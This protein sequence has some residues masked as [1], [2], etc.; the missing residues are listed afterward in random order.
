MS[1]T[2]FLIKINTILKIKS[3]QGWNFFLTMSSVF[4]PQ[5]VTSNMTLCF[6]LVFSTV[7]V[8]YIV[9]TVLNI[10]LFFCF[11]SFKCNIFIQLDKISQVL[12]YNLH[13]S[14]EVTD[15]GQLTL[16]QSLTVN[17]GTLPDSQ[18]PTCYIPGS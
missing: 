16:D 4:R 14:Y 12:H 2:Y 5:V 11:V 15:T 7:F 3:C 8:F 10:W 17:K 6:F 18:G 9:D 13:F 1:V